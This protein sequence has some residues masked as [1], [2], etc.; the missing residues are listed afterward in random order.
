MLIVFHD[1][2]KK[3][4][5]LIIYFFDFF[6]RKKNFSEFFS[7]GAM[8]PMAPSLDPRLPW[9]QHHWAFVGL[10]REQ[11]PCSVSSSTHTIWT[12]DGPARGMGANSDELC[13]PLFVNPASNASCHS[14][15]MWPNPLLIKKFHF[16][17]DVP[18]I[19][20]YT[21]MFDSL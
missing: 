3:F 1:L 12:R 13:S 6:F 20:S 8:A 21:C 19:L 2:F 4:W 7:G 9:S 5:G 11:S 18:I 16:L 10:F 14:G 17:T 15:Q